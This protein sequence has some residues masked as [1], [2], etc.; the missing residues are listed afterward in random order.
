MPNSKQKQINVLWVDLIRVVACFLVVLLHVCAQLIFNE[1]IFR[2]SPVAWW[3]TN[4][5]RTIS[6]VA[7]PL[8][9]MISGYLLLKKDE[10]ILVFYTKRAS[11]ILVPFLFWQIFYLFFFIAIGQNSWEGGRYLLYAIKDNSVSVHFWFLYALISVYIIVP[12]LRKYVLAAD[13]KNILCFLCFWFIYH[14]LGDTL[15]ILRPVSTRFSVEFITLYS[16]YFVLGAFLGKI[17]LSKKAAIW[18]LAGFVLLVVVSMLGT[19][20]CLTHWFGEMKKMELFYRRTS[21]NVIFMSIFAFLCLRYWGEQIKS[22]VIVKGLHFLVPLTFG[23]YLIHYL[24]IH[25]SSFHWIRKSV[26]DLCDCSWALFALILVSLS[27]FCC[28]GVIIYAIRKI[29]L[30]KWIAP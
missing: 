11:R 26:V 12:F 13:N 24:F 15:N 8:F 3:S 18:C 17:N 16:G 4:F 10:P 7:V 30:G 19:W 20:F 6:V 29:P 2:N 1:T 22:D 23:I 9:F 5:L 21:P 25:Q 28:S 27:L 14:S